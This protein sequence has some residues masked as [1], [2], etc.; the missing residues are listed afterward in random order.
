MTEPIPFQSNERWQGDLF[1]LKTKDRDYKIH[2][3]GEYWI[4]EHRFKWQYPLDPY[5]L[6]DNHQGLWKVYW[7]S[8]GK[9]LVIL[10]MGLCDQ[11]TDIDGIPDSLGLRFYG[12]MPFYGQNRLAHSWGEFNEEFFFLPALEWQIDTGIAY[13]SVRAKVAKLSSNYEIEN[14]LRQT[15]SLYKGQKRQHYQ[16]P[17]LEQSLEEP[18]FDNWHTLVDEARKQI[19]EGQLDKVVLSR[20]KTLSFDRPLPLGYV[21]SELAQIDEQSYL[22][23]LQAPSGLA[24][25][26]RSPERLL[27]WSGRYVELEAIAGTR[28]RVDSCEE[29]KDYATQLQSSGK[30]LLEHRV[31]TEYI[32]DMLKKYC[33][34]WHQ[35]EQERLFQLKHVQHIISRFSGR[36]KTGVHPVDFCRAL[37][38][39]PAVG[40]RPLKAALDFL[41]NKEPIDRGWFAGPIGWTD[42]QNG[43][44][45]IGIRTALLTDC[46]LKVFAGAGV[47]AES[48]PSS[49][50]QETEDKMKNFMD[51][52]ELRL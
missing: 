24:F 20:T 9:K 34:Q 31:V 44:F 8:K 18:R 12:G 13:L 2:D 27:A 45:A 50:W 42:G 3:F 10:G 51:L 49:E 26:G 1:S 41:A 15:V 23:A 29:D 35:D 4:A 47:V 52:F 14:A 33:D 36:C 7:R 48:D 32:S 46:N 16:M 25:V 40:G 30:D 6:L 19:A 39:T 28:K 22:F 38:P 5:A 17:Q 37:H 21:M 11:R 43:D